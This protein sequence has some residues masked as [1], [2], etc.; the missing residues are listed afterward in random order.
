[1]E[2]KKCKTCGEEDITKFYELPRT[3]CKKCS[4]NQLEEWKKLHPQRVKETNKI[5][6]KYWYEKH[7]QKNILNPP[8]YSPDTMKLCCRC[9]RFLSITNFTRTL[10]T[11]DGIQ[12]YCKDCNRERMKVWRE[13]NR[14]RVNEIGRK[15]QRKYRERNNCRQAS[16]Y[17][18]SKEKQSCSIQDCKAGAEMHHFD[19]NNP[20]LVIWLCRKHHRALFHPA[21]S[22]IQQTTQ[23]LGIV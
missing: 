7:K 18:Y 13:N 21:T 2:H 8:L 19:Y 22:L 6:G 15:S 20:H 1:M 9:K 12:S 17:Y 10:G 4:W 3:I 5:R 11:S 16:N 23:L 14:E